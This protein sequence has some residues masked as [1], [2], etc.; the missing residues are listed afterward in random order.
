[1]GTHAWDTAENIESVRGLTKAR[2]GSEWA[3]AWNES[4]ECA[5]NKLE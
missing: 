1:M 5:H 2:G 4:T 3:D